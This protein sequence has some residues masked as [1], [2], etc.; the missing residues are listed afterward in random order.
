MQA[1]VAISPVLFVP[2]GNLPSTICSYRPLACCTRQAFV[3]ISPVFFVPN[4]PLLAAP[5]KLVAISPVFFV[6]N[7]PLLAAPR[8]L[9]WQSPHYLFLPS[10]CLLHHASFRGNFPCIIC[11]QRPLACCTMQAFVA[12]S[13]VLFVPIAPFVPHVPSLAAPCKLSWQSPQYSLFLTSPCLL[14]HA[15]FRGNFPSICCSY[16][17]LACCTIQAFVAISPVFFVPNVPLLA[18]PCKLSWQFPQYLFHC[19]RFL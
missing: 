1:F 11:S 10:P 9:S 6:P 8:K 18:A 7:V 4:V 12:I 19:C 16:R 15:S 5:Y 14:H 2:N 13:P 17:P 3:A